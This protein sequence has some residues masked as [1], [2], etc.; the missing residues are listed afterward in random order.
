[1]ITENLIYL[2]EDVNYFVSQDLMTGLDEDG[3]VQRPRPAT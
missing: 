1:M 2:K 3:D